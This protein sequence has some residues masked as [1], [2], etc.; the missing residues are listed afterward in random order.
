[1]N[2]A[3]V[4]VKSEAVQQAI[5]DATKAACERLD[6]MF[7]GHDNGGITSNFQGLLHELIE[8]MLTGDDP[9]DGRA[10]RL[11]QLALTNAS[12]GNET[13]DGTAFVVTKKIRNPE[14][15]FGVDLVVGALNDNENGFIRFCGNQER[16]DPYT[17]YEA[18]VSGACKWLERTGKTQAEEKLQIRPVS[19]SL[20]KNRW[21]FSNE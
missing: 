15:Q 11:P 20:D 17:S 14:Q 10:T 21:E 5:A 2:T 4:H 16:L 12:F 8:T 19:V 18:A 7:P 1:M 6:E 13:A 9:R 3:S